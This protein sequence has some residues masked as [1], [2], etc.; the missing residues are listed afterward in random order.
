VIIA[1]VIVMALFAAGR[2]GSTGTP[3]AAPIAVESPVPAAPE[4]TPGLGPVAVDVPIKV[5]G[6]LDLGG[7]QSELVYETSIPEPQE[8]RA[9]LLARNALM[10]LMCRAG[11]WLPAKAYGRRCDRISRSCVE[12][13]G[14]FDYQVLQIGI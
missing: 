14:R 1:V 2:F 11:G 6:A 10:A 3:A 5:R 8:V 12:A 13:W 4:P 7:L 9:G